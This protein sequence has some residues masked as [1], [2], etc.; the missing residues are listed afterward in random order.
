MVDA[1]YD[2]GLGMNDVKCKI[3]AIS[4]ENAESVKQRI[5]LA[6]DAMKRIDD[7]V[8]MEDP[9]PALSAFREELTRLSESTVCNKR[10]LDWNRRSIKWSIPRIVFSTLIRR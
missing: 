9:E 4:E 1:T 2:A 6:K 3:G 10:E 8:K 7:I 5:T